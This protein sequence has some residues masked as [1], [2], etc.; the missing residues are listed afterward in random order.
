M[1][2]TRCNQWFCGANWGRIAAADLLSELPGYSEEDDKVSFLQE[3]TLSWI[4]E[5]SKVEKIV[6][7]L[8]HN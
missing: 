5:G 1:Y 8:S 4:G 2:K 6:E 7:P 3:G